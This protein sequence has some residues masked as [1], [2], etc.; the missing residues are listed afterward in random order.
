MVGLGSAKNIAT[1]QHI[2][3]VHMWNI[4]YVHVEKALGD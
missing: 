4:K 1:V 2:F 3:R